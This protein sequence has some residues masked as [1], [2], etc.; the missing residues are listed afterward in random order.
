[1]VLYALNDLFLNMSISFQIEPKMM[2]FKS[3]SYVS[4][5]DHLHEVIFS[6]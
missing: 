5:L 6:T 1:M 2:N 4:Y 3:L